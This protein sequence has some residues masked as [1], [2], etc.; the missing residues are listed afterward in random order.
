MTQDARIHAVK[1]RLERAITELAMLPVENVVPP[2]KPGRYL[3]NT[4]S[5]VKRDGAALGWVLS[6][7][8]DHLIATHAEKIKPEVIRGAPIP[9]A[10][11][12]A[13]ISGLKFAHESRIRKL[14]AYVDNQTVVDQLNEDGAKVRNETLKRLWR[15]ATDLLGQFKDTRVYWIPRERNQ[16]AD[17]LVRIQLG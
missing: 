1:K 2:V 3:L 16:V 9:G 17:A 6:D 11:Y 14:R 10:E 7:P 13:L 5:G 12:C 8:D 15:E 4:D